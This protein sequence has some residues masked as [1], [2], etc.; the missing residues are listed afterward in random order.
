MATSQTQKKGGVSR[1]ALLGLSGFETGVILPAGFRVR[2]IAASVALPPQ[3]GTV[4]LQTVTVGGTPG[5]GTV[6]ID[7]TTVVTTAASDAVGLVA[8]RI[9]AATPFVG[10]TSGQTWY[11]YSTGSAGLVFYTKPVPGSKATTVALTITGTGGYTGTASNVGGT[12]NTPFYGTPKLSAGTVAIGSSF[13]SIPVHN[14]TITGAATTGGLFV[15]DG[16]QILIPASAT[17]DAIGAVVAATS[18]AGATNGPWIPSYSASTDTVTLTGLI[19]ANA[20]SGTGVT[21]TVGSTGL[22]VGSSTAT[23]VNAGVAAVTN[24]VNAQNLPTTVMGASDL[25][26]ASTAPRSS[27]A[28]DA[29]QITVGG[30]ATAGQVISV[31]GKYYTLVSGD[32]SSTTTLAA[33][34]VAQLN[35]IPGYYATNS[36]AVITLYVTDVQKQI[37]VVAV[38]TATSMT[39][40]KVTYNEDQTLWISLGATTAGYLTLGVVGNVNAYVQLE[41][42]S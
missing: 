9:V 10:A 15:V 6:I 39:L 31:G 40:T 25:T 37:P 22:T 2:A 4:N 29:Q 42:I 16:V 38:G 28:L 21:V 41:K 1:Q 14:F 11:A 3:R 5:T 20:N 32:I 7:G 27:N 34:I 17:I 24:V 8:A 23:V 35:S 12:A 33:A 36:S 19:P 26:V 13:P 30:T 18:F